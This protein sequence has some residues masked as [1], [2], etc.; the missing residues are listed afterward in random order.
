VQAECRF[1]NPSPRLPSLEQKLRDADDIITRA[2]DKLDKL[3]EG[4]INHQ[5]LQL[6]VTQLPASTAVVFSIREEPKSS[7][8]EAKF[9]YCAGFRRRW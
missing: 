9:I 3:G 4:G 2:E 5:H 1:L 6:Q 7:I 8:C